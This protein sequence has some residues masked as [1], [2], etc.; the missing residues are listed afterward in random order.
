M[1]R[2]SLILALALLAAL[3]VAPG[4]MAQPSCPHGPGVS[5]ISH[6][7]DECALIQFIC[8]E[9]QQKFDN[10]CGCGCIQTTASSLD[11]SEKAPALDEPSRLFEADLPNRTCQGL[12]TPAGQV[13]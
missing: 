5:Y 13:E 7:P 2:I 4:V 1:K 10:E 9:G 3:F 6:N 12:E 8:A 11:G